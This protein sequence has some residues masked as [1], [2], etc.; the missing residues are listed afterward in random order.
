MI[1]MKR[2]EVEIRFMIIN[3]FVWKKNLAIIPLKWVFSGWTSTVDHFNFAIGIF[4]FIMA[5]DT[6]A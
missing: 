4:Q 3:I 1:T 6:V 5:L 2:I